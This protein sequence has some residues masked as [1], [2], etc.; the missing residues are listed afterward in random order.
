MSDGEKKLGLT[1]DLCERTSQ[2]TSMA[3]C[4]VLRREMDHLQSEWQD[5][6]A[7]IHQVGGEGTYCAVMYRNIVIVVQTFGIKF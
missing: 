1:Q 7:R 5:Y 2:N 4:E 6:T 3:G